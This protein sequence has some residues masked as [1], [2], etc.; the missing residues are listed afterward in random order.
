[1]PR[2]ND[3]KR[4][5]VLGAGPIIIGQACEFDYSGTQAIK[6]L[7]EEGYEV[8]LVNSNPAT[9]MT[10]PEYSDAT[11]IEP[12]VPDAVEDII[13]KERPDALLPTLGG[14][15]ALN[16]A[17]AL[18]ERGVLERYGVE[19][20]GASIDSIRKAESRDLF[21]KTMREAGLECARGGEVSTIKGA[22]ALLAET[23]LP[24]II[25]PSFTLGGLGGGVAY[26]DDEFD[27]LV[28]EGLD[29]SPNHTVLIEESLLGWKEFEMEVMRDRADNG[30]II[31]SIENID[32]MGVHTGDSLTVAPALTL[33]DKELQRMRDAS[34]RCLS[35]IGV[36]TG[37]SNVQ[38]AINPADGRM[39]VIEMNPRVSRSSALAS[40]ATGFPIA[41][42][43]ARLAV[44]YTLDEIEN[45]ITRQTM[46][47][48]EPSIDY[49]VVKAP[50][51]AFDKFPESDDTLT[52]RMK[53]VGEAM[54][55]GGTFREALQKALRSLEDNFQGFVHT[56]KDWLPAGT[57]WRARF[58]KPKP[59]R[60]RDIAS[61][62]QHGVSNDDLHEWTKVD[63]WFLREMRALIDD[64]AAMKG[65][66]LETLTTAELRHLKAEGFSDEQIA[67]LCGG[68]T[69][70]DAVRKQRIRLDVRP[71]YRTVDTCAAEFAA[72]TPYLYSTY[73]GEESETAPGRR[74][75]VV[76]L[77][78]GP[79]RIGQGIEFDYC[80]VRAC[81]ALRE[82]GFETVMVNCNP[83]TVSTDFDTADVHYFEPLT[84][85]DVLGICD[86][87]QP[88]GVVVQLGGQTPLKLARA[89]ENAGVRVLGTTAADI[90]R[91]EDRRAFHD[92][93]NSLGVLQPRG[94]T[95]ESVDE[96]CI[97]A[98]EIGYPVLI[99]PS[100]V[101]GGR[102]MT[103]AYDEKFLRPF[104]QREILFGPGN[105][106]EIV[107]YLE[108]AFEYDVDAVSDGERT[109]IAG[110][111]Q[112]IE[113]AGVHSGDSACCIPPFHA[114]PALMLHVHD[115]VETLAKHFCVRGLINI[116]LAVKADKVY[117]LEVN[118]RASR[119][120]PF[121]S[122]ATGVP[123]IRI[124][125]KVMA[126][127]KLK[128]LG[129][130]PTMPPGRVAVKEAVFPFDRFP[131][132]DPILGPEMRST[133]EVMG[134]DLDFGRAFA[135]AQ[136]AA[137]NRLPRD[138]GLVFISVHERDKPTACRIARR[139]HTLGYRICATAG[140]AAAISK[141]GVP[142]EIVRKIHEGT[143]TV[144]DLLAR[145]EDRVVLMINTPLG[146]ASAIDDKRI[147]RVAIRHGV[148]YTTTLSAATAAVSA[149][150]ALQAGPLEPLSLQS[151]M[152]LRDRD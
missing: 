38:F 57:D 41:R 46:A 135:K 10:D 6:A 76:I 111:M 21:Q 40:K 74:Q 93:L 67:G 131:E 118:P 49:V 48:F 149:I 50:R 84:L 124:G 95:A 62:M 107:E 26:T 22:R 17:V 108:D 53:S 119:T 132:A 7:R 82:Q 146:K 128:D 33:S 35:A 100:F 144:L 56:Q 55:I 143:P 9:I 32:P 140:T 20:L 117:V 89:L 3:I 148:P 139:L 126:G 90:H 77:G 54:S 39:I 79:N 138:G 101:L 73:T 37:G 2:R 27:R 60:Y 8:V 30:V 86:V 18:H 71:S 59:T 83:E 75:R 120:L 152:K 52:T 151:G 105:P 34:L 94:T 122:K 104:L 80:C 92:A 99:R 136:M 121:V 145:D 23:G 129:A 123:W 96:A 16:V 63:P 115:I 102:G 4:I 65:K 70:A 147:R 66:P 78:A 64:A 116:Q 36:E 15:T 150:E 31:C 19:V 42:V 25:R 87:E 98:G 125:T 68:E 141:F 110:V 13:R 133:G 44:G 58:A 28:Q 134:I 43:A 61:A 72:F 24:A 11:Y 88:L 51:F 12:L 113:E 103:I 5:L 85:E 81:D 127:A 142:V 29:A 130:R 45:A 97:K 109:V 114:P 91:A 47:A 112:H 137:G 69:T 1:M 14:Q 106:L